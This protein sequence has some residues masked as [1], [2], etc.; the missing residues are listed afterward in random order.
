MD[1]IEMKVLYFTKEGFH[2]QQAG[3]DICNG[4]L[5]KSG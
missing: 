5:D 2:I 4:Q 3:L 1:I